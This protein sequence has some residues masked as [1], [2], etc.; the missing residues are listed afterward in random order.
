[1]F[2][3]LIPMGEMIDSKFGSKL[4]L[5]IFRLLMIS[6]LLIVPFFPDSN[7]SGILCAAT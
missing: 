6:G 3:P 5:K 2:N 7:Y 4:K 1:M